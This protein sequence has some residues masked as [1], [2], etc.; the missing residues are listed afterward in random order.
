MTTSTSHDT[1][2]RSAASDVP[3]RHEAR[4][5]LEPPAPPHIVA[6]LMRDLSVPPILASVLYQRG[7]HQDALGQLSPPLTLTQIPDLG[8]A[9]ERLEHALR[10]KKRIMIHG[11][12]DADGIS[13]TAVL[14]LGLRALGGTVVPFIPHRLT[15]G[16]G[17]AP[18]RV[19]EHAERADLFVTVDCGI[20]NVAEIDALQRRG[21]EV[22]VSDHHHPGERRPDCLIVHPATSPLAKKGLPALTGSGVAYHLLWALHER[23]GLEPPLDYSDLA[24]IGIIADVAPLMGE[25]RALVLAGLE[26]M[27]DSVWPGVIATLKKTQLSAPSAR[28]VAF[29]IAPRLNAAGRLGEADLGLELLTTASERRA[30]ELAHYLDARNKDRRQIQDA[31]FAEAMERVDPDAP[32]LVLHKHDWHP[33]VMGIVA[34]KVLEHHYKPVFI[35]ADGKG[36]VRSTPGISAVASLD[37]ASH[38][39]KRYGGHSQAAGFAIDEARLP[40]FRA[41]IYDFVATHP[42]PQRQVRPDALLAPNDLDLDLIRA[43]GNF[44]PYGQGHPPPLFAFSGTL[45]HAR[46]VGQGGK[47][48]QLRVAG[49]KGIAWGRGDEAE[50]LSLGHEVDVA[51]HLQVNEWRGTKSAE[52]I[53]ED[54]RSAAGLPSL[55]DSPNDS[56]DDSLD[57]TPDDSALAARIH[58]HRPSHRDRLLV[59]GPSVDSLPSWSPGDLGP[60]DGLAKAD[61]GGVWIRALPLEPATPLALTAPLAQ[62]I[63]ASLAHPRLHLYVDIDDQLAELETHL[64]HY[65][66]VADVRRTFV[67]LSK[68]QPIPFGDVKTTLCRQVIDELGLL[69]ARGRAYR[70]QKRDPYSAPTLVAGLRERYVLQTLLSAYRYRDDAG[71][72]LTLRALFGADENGSDDSDERWYG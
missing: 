7:L 55:T 65:P 41:A 48:L 32:A 5:R 9:A 71:F 33:G 43:I 67:A 52:F 56:P 10:H 63:R 46:A 36:S 60:E 12:Y 45:E 68:G 50:T 24:S 54:I 35:V 2:S 66:T 59:V 51:V 49:V 18:Q 27:P 1:G 44:E 8:A 42:V 57:D 15:D 23:L 34:S 6:R 38:T 20:S 61:I 62:I 14:T 29:V 26:R 47:H 19:D 53:A 70:G 69:D 58:R 13:G 28:D 11:D 16:Y 21:V 37:A 3:A 25:N 31:M 72:A 4:W 17:I 40:D 22:I 64:G 39:L 30:K